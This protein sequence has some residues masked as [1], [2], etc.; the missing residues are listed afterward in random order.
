[1]R[2]APFPGT[3]CAEAKHVLDR[4]GGEGFS[5]GEGADAR[6]DGGKEG[7]H[8][9]E[10]ALDEGPLGAPRPALLAVRPRRLCRGGHHLLQV[11]QESETHDIYHYAIDI[12]GLN[13]L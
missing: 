1:M 8:G 12:S 13:V 10:P 4:L 7:A 3:G 5:L 9:L 2:S 11:P 6:V